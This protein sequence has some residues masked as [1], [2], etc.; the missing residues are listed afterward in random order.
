MESEGAGRPNRRSIAI[1]GHCAVLVGRVSECARVDRLVDGVSRGRSG[2]L[3]IAGEAGA[4][5]TALLAY[6]RARA[7]SVRSLVAAGFEAER[8]LP[9]AGLSLLVRPVQRRLDVVPEVQKAALEAALALGPPVAADRFAAYGGVLS[10]L[11]AAV[12]E[13]PLLVIVDDAQW[14]DAASLEALLFTARRLLDEGIGMVFA[15]RDDERSAEQFAGLPRLELHGLAEE[16]VAALVERRAGIRPSADVARRVHRATGGNPLAVGELACALSRAQLEGS[17]PLDDPL[18][19]GADVQRAVGRR[20]L[21]LPVETRRALLYAAAEPM[22][23]PDMLERA[24]NDPALASSLAP[25]ESAG[26]IVVRPDAVEFRHPLFRSVAY[27]LADAPERRAAHAALAKTFEPE[28]SRARRAWHL[29]RATT[30]LDETVARELEAVGQS[31]RDRGAPESAGRT[32]GTAARLTPSRELRIRRRLEAA[33]A[34][35]M[36]AR[37]DP[38]RRLLDEALAEAPDDPCLRADV[39]RL[40]ARLETMTGGS[41]HVHEMLVGEA[42]RVARYDAD[43]AASLLSDAAFIAVTDGQL[44]LALKL[45]TRAHPRSA[46]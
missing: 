32:L 8:E 7:G 37:L 31:A 21:A 2:C 9:Y 33:Q 27:Q 34:F 13:E 29:A 15:A 30:G 44:R 3:L 45:A 24:L 41:Q 35:A 11:A 18:P 42:E 17:T 20:L 25:A 1:D 4:G 40:R 5:K 10:L 14:L 38:A 16:D 36:A 22:N 23:G 19:V 6:A 28:A 46:A 43:R 12:E 39:Q 26:L